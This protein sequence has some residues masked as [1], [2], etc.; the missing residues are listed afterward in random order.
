MNK[1]ILIIAGAILFS[2]CSC[3]AES[4][5]QKKQMIEERIYE[6]KAEITASQE[7]ENSTVQSKA[8]TE[9]TSKDFMEILKEKL[10]QKS[11]G[12]SIIGVWEVKND[13]Y[14]AIYE[15]VKHDNQYFGK[16]HYYNDGKTEVKAQNNQNDYFLDGLFFNDGKYSTA[17]MY[18]PNG[19][20]LKVIF[21]LEG[22]ELT[23]EMTIEGH[24]YQEVWKRKELQFTKSVINESK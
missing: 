20:K 3:R 23:A 14:Q 8:K 15:I 13:Y 5:K 24:P 16:V 4:E 2:F 11:K 21:N 18:M 9:K 7:K 1:H 17:T 12:D 22:N 10:P 6:I 19:N